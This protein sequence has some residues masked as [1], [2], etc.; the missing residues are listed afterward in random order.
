MRMAD[1]AVGSA[2]GCGSGVRRR[3]DA[4]GGTGCR[5]LLVSLQLLPASGKPGRRD[6]KEKLLAHRKKSLTP[7]GSCRICRPLD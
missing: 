3:G 6:I 5:Q 7:G 2:N 4:G 1:G